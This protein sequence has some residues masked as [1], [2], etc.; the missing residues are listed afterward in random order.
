MILLATNL[1]YFIAT[2]IGIA[3]R[4]LAHVC[5]CMCVKFMFQKAGDFTANY[6]SFLYKQNGLRFYLLS[7]MKGEHHASPAATLGANVWL[8]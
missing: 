8:R 2:S 7:M 1:Y 4:D 6:I 3:Q 5:V